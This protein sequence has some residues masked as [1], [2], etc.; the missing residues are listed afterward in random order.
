MSGSEVVKAQ[1]GTLTKST[2]TLV[3]PTG[4]VTAVFWEEW[5]ACSTGKNLHFH[6]F[7]GEKGNYSGQ[8]YT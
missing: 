8:S 1:K 5:I 2:T 3:D 4:S 7:E 6:Q